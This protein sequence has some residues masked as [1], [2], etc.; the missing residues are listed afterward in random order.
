MH[1]IHQAIEMFCVSRYQSTKFAT[2][3][4]QKDCREVA[5]ERPKEFYAV[6][7]FTNHIV[8]VENFIAV[9]ENENQLQSCKNQMS[10]EPQIRKLLQRLEAEAF[11]QKLEA[12]ELFEVHRANDKMKITFC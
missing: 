12:L 10:Q 8:S 1:Q 7:R 3:P 2:P 6:G 9:N 5:Q 11:E 4:C